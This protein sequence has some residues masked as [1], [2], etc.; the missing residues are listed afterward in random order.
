MATKENRMVYIVEIIRYGA[1]ELGVQFFGVFDDLD[2][3]HEKMKEYNEYRGGKY[4]EYYVTETP[5]NPDKIHAG[6]KVRYEV[7]G[8]KLID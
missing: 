2:V 5:I 4:P 1:P 6:E 7:G 8:K 3:V